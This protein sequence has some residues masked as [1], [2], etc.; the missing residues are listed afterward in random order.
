MKYILLAAALFLN[1]QANETKGAQPPPS[2]VKTVMV[3][4]GYANSLQNYVGTLYY[5]RNSKLASETS[6]VVSKIYVKEGQSVKEGTVLLKLESSILEA[7]VKAKQATLDSFLAQQTKQQKDLQR[8][9]ALLKKQSIAQ[10][11]YDNTYY[12]LEALNSEIDSHK[13]ELL[14]MKIELQK[15][16]IQAPFDAVIVKRDVYIGEWVAVGNSVFNVVN[17]QSIEARVNIPSSLLE[18]LSV[19]Q[20]LQAKIN[21]KDIEVSVKSIIPLADKSSRTF[22]VKLSFN[23]KNNLIEGM[24][25]DI[26]IPTLKKEKALLVPRDAV[27][28]RFGNFVVFSVVD[29]KAI[30]IPVDVINYTKNEAAITA[31]GLKVNMKVITK[32]NERVFPN[33]PVVEKAN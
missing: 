28:K 1:I 4:E 7:K 18:T 2:L 32:G 9:D 20:K 25:I 11:S 6:G 26:K 8:A 27:I 33:M 12:T 3:K 29:S 17:P 31:G 5:D 22:P 21:D 23:S 16:S 19:G 30:M 13:A 15:K 14:S 10:S 24:R